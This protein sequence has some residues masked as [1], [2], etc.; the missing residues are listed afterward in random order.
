MD[1]MKYFPP[2]AERCDA[3]QSWIKQFERMKST[4]SLTQWGE[5]TKQP[6]KVLTA[7]RP[8]TQREDKKLCIIFF[9]RSEVAPLH[10]LCETLSSRQKT[11]RMRFS[12]E[13]WREEEKKSWKIP[14]ALLK[15][16]FKVSDWIYSGWKVRKFFALL[17]RGTWRDC[18]IARERHN[19][20]EFECKLS[21]N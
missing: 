5:L 2:S 17:V 7:P 21:S 18:E 3:I 13:K 14:K 1:Q 15:N 12:G 6:L 11:R 16:V 19:D 4:G 20:D 10:S 8:C 9:T